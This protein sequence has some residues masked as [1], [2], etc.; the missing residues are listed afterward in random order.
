MRNKVMDTLPIPLRRDAER[1]VYFTSRSAE[2]TASYVKIEIT[3]EDYYAAEA[4]KS[5]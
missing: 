4:K 5:E 2:K 1:L 3:G